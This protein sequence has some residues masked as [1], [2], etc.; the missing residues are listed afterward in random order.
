[1]CRRCTCIIVVDTRIGVIDFNFFLYFTY[2]F[3]FYFLDATNPDTISLYYYT[4]Y[5]RLRLRRMRNS[6]RAFIHLYIYIIP[7][8]PADTNSFSIIM[9]VYYISNYDRVVSARDYAFLLFY[10]HYR[11]ISFILS[12]RSTKYPRP[13]RVWK[14]VRGVNRRPLLSRITYSFPAV[15]TT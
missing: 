15:H 7:F 4:M 13:W 9:C 1:V 11:V 3:W 10:S 12:F 14:C 2:S 6:G 8:I 5:K